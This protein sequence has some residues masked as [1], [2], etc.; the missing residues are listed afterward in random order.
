MKDPAGDGGSQW[1]L[2]ANVLWNTNV[3]SN[4][5]Q[6]VECQREVALTLHTLTL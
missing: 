6:S 2:E 1:W 4:C 3:I 5:Q